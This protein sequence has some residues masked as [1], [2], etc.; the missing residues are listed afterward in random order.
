MKKWLTYRRK[1]EILL[2]LSGFLIATILFRISD[3]VARNNVIVEPTI[4]PVITSSPEINAKNEEKSTEAKI[5]ARVLYG[6]NDYH[7]SENGKKAVFEVIQNR[8]K[9]SFGEF[10]N[11]IEEVC[12]KPQQWQGYVEDGEYLETDYQLALNFLNDNSGARVIPTNC[13]FLTV[14]AGKVIVR[15]EWNNG[16]EWTVE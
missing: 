4:E 11:T 1:R 16:S 12:N 2:F 15:T 9:C 13:Y 5:M 6:I 3:A 10:G 14:K 8:V 7:L